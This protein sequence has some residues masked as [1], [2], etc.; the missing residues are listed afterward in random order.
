MFTVA[1]TDVPTSVY[2]GASA[3]EHGPC[4]DHGGECKAPEPDWWYTA[5]A[6]CE[7]ET[8]SGP[9][10]AHRS[11]GPSPRCPRR[12]EFHISYNETGEVGIKVITH[13]MVFTHFFFVF[14]FSLPP[15]CLIPT[16]VLYLRL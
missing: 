2:E 1:A 3:A 14:P 9:G 7:L 13:F 16:I 15:V 11:M 5:C 6:D 12:G 4:A 10:I 8:V